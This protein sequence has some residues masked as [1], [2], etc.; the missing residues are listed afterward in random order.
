[1]IS[2]VVLNYKRNLFPCL[3]SIRRGTSNKHEVIVVDNGNRYP[4]M[5][6]QYIDKY[7]GLKKNEGV[8]ARNY[9]KLA[10]KYD[11][12]ACIDDDVIVA[13]GWDEVLLT[14]LEGDPKVA[15]VGPC[16]HYVF[17]DLSNF[18]NSGGVPGTYVHVLTGYCWMH[19]N[20]KE[21]L[22]PWN[23]GVSSWH[24]ETYI[25]FQ[26]RERG[27]TFKVTPNVCIHDSQRGEISDKSWED[28]N[29]KIDRIKNRFK[30]DS[31][32]LEAY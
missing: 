8:V 16:G 1:M 5:Q 31:L 7:I 13:E 27:C 20:M 9:G 11:Y 32:H 22:L 21:G 19:K 26:M 3:E 24:D 12:I 17:P 29:D 23:W 30:Y 15:G 18:N 6:S 4:M 14:F 2:I 25:Q 10:A 28:H